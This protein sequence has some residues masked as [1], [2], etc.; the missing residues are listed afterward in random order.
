VDG[1]VVRARNAG[2]TL[3]PRTKTLEAVRVSRPLLVLGVLALALFAAGTRPA[4]ATFHFMSISELGAGFLGDPNVQFVELRVDAPGQTN[5]TDTRL[6]VFDKD[7]TPAVLLLTPTGVPDGA[8]GRNILYA[9]TAFQSATGVTPDFVIPAG[10]VS[11]SGMVCWGAPGESPPDPASWDL[12]KPENYV[13]CVAYGSYSHDTRPSSGTPTSLTPGDGIQSLTRIKNNGATGSNDADFTLAAAGPCNNAGTCASLAPNPT[14]TATPP[15][16][17]QLTCRRAVIKASHKFAAAALQARAACETQRLKGKVAGPCPDA[18]ASGKIAAADAKRT[19]AITKACGALAP[20]DAGF[21][22]SCPGYT[23]ACADALAT[24]ADV[25]ACVDCGNRRANAELVGAVYAAAP[26]AALLKCQLGLGKAATSHYRAVGA[27]LAKCEDGV[28]RGKIAAP[29]PDAKTAGKITARN[30]KL[31][32]TLCKV[33][34]GKD[35][36]CDG[37]ADAAPATLGLT[38]CPAR[39]VPGGAACGNVAIGSL[40]DVVTCVECVATFESVCTT[41]LAAHPG[42]LPLLC[43]AP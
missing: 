39:T 41:A 20:G 15:G 43:S 11:P 24:I 22:A 32:S 3:A 25:S 42:E 8:T 34:G 26:D 14:P 9:T 23:G 1:V 29:C 40:A 16:K 36:L 30:A 28:A 7:G 5:L 31:R 21:G 35:K 13:D 33:C 2:L 37:N 12:Q 10:V 27:L 6:T 4:Q 18:K 17:A 38:S 19:K